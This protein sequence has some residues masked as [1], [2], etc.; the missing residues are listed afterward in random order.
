MHTGFFLGGGEAR[1]VRQEIIAL[2]NRRFR[3]A[4][5]IGQWARHEDVVKS[6]RAAFLG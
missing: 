3:Y 1:R 4:W 2:I 6:R 5:L